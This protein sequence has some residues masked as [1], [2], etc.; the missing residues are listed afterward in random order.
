M[1]DDRILIINLCSADYPGG[2]ERV[3]ASI[4]TALSDAGYKVEWLTQ[5]QLASGQIRVLNTLAWLRLK[6]IAINIMFARKLDRQGNYA[7]IITN[8]FYG[9]HIR[10]K[11]CIHIY[12]GTVAGYR[13]AVFGQL[14][15]F[16][17][18][19]LR[20]I[21]ILERFS[22]RGKIVVAVSEYCRR[23]LERYYR[24][25]ASCI[26]ENAVDT[27]FFTPVSAEEQKANKC[28]FFGSDAPV[29]IFVGRVEYAKGADILNEIIY[30]SQKRY[31]FLICAGE[32]EDK[33]RI[34]DASNVVYMLGLN[35]KMM[36]LAYQVADV[37][38][39]PSR[40]EGYGLAVA[41]ALSSGVPVVGSEV[42]L[43]AD[44]R[45]RDP[46]IGRYILD[47]DADASEYLCRIGEAVADRERLSICSREYILH[48][49]DPESCN[50]RWQQIVLALN[51]SNAVDD[52]SELAV[53]LPRD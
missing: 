10:N 21:E 53:L 15:V 22:G 48:A 23:E 29:I 38:L 50:R 49:G 43:M 27:S 18:L 45:R 26:M 33:Y 41:E 40:Y 20:S 4:A 35:P 11:R 37:F 52:G 31:N 25:Q 19:R 13:R 44:I 7:A 14:S 1:P 30:K 8:G 16:S 5:D 42:G 47:T 39:L 34:K 12:H 28:K 32:V 17:R 9:T 2:V 24:L 3:L 51:G 46:V 6:E 36:R